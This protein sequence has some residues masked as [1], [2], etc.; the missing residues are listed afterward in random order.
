M[1]A[2]CIVFGTCGGRYLFTFSCN[3]EGEGGNG[4]KAWE[5]E[6]EVIRNREREGEKE[7]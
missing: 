7:K 1:I 6:R 5:K 3:R 2:Q 4:E